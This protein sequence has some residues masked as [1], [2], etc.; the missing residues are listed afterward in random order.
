MAPSWGPAVPAAIIGRDGFKQRLT[1]LKRRYTPFR[2]PWEIA[3]FHLDLLLLVRIEE[4]ISYPA[5]SLASALEY[6]AFDM[7]KMGG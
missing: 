6:Q 7:G 3:Q 4:T 1:A 5:Q 2:S